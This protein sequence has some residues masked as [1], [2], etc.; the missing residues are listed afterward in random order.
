M[1][2]QIVESS[3]YPAGAY[4]NS[5]FASLPTDSRF[6]KCTA[7][8]VMPSSSID[9]KTIEFNLERYQA[10]NVYLIQDTNIEVSVVIQKKDNSLPDKTVTVGPVNNIL[11]SLFESVR[12]TINDVPI[13]ISPLNHHYKCY[14]SNCLTYSSLVKAA[15]LSAQGWYGDFSGHFGPTTSNSGFKER[16]ELFRENYGQD[17]PY[18]KNGIT[19]FGR[20]MHDLIS[21]E[22]GTEK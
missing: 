5:F 4:A 22:T 7:Q 14:F 16:S 2:A 12:L 18:R 8:K 6:L 20:L 10:G 17:S 21:C 19:L 15:Q 9:G 1:E 13:T 11:H 3:T